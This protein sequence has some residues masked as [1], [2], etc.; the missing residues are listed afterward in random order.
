MQLKWKIKR[1]NFTAAILLTGCFMLTT[2]NVG[3]AEEGSKVQIDFTKIQRAL[4]KGGT[5]SGGTAAPA[6]S[7]SASQMP[8]NMS[9][10]T[11][12]P[13][14]NS[15]QTGPAA[16]GM[17][18]EKMNQVMGETMGNAFAGSDMMAEM[19]KKVMA[20]NMGSIQESV[21][22]SVMKSIQGAMQQQPAMDSPAK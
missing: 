17:M 9:A 7:V 6:P 4:N 14:A 5:A 13:A 8:A 2:A 21:Q 22:A 20:E 3:M 19:Q 16:I 10:K 1:G 18:D 12:A 15:M 11:P